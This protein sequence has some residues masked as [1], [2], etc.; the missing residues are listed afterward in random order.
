MLRKSFALMVLA[1]VA[2]LAQTTPRTQLVRGMVLDPSGAVVPDATVT[3]KRGKNSINPPA[4][5]GEAGDFR[6]DAVPEGTYSLEVIREGF[7]L[8]VTPLRIG[9]RL[10][11]RSGGGVPC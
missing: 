11:N 10:G 6:F 1:V 4:L 2:V 9:A 3:L 5:T 7:G 8:S